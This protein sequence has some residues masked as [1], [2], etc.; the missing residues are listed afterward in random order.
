ME[1]GRMITDRSGGGRSIALLRAAVLVLVLTGGLF[2]FSALER[3]I[4]RGDEA[5]TGVRISGVLHEEIGRELFD[6]RVHSRAEVLE[7]QYP[8]PGTTWWDTA[9][10]LAVHDPKQSPIYYLAAR[11]WVQILGRSLFV[12]RSLSALLGLLCLPLAFLVARELF[13]DRAAAWVAVGVIAVAPVR[14]VYD[15][16]AR[17]YPL[18]AVLIL[19]STWLLLVAL[20]RARTDGGTGR[21]LFPLYAAALTAA[22]YTHPLTVLVAAAHVAFVVIDERRCWT[23]PARAHMAAVA[24]AGLCYAPLAA[25]VAAQ[26]SAPH[27]GLAWLREAMPPLDWISC[28]AVAVVRIFYD[29]AAPGS[30]PAWMMLGLVPLGIAAAAGSLVLWAAPASAR[31]LLV[32]QIAVT[33]V[34]FV[35]AD[36][37]LGGFRTCVLRYLFP[38]VIALQLCVAFGIAHLL[39]DSR[40]IWRAAG[41]ASAIVLALSGVVSG[42]AIVTAEVWWLNPVGNRI[43]RIARVVHAADRP[44][45]I[46]PYTAP[47]QGNHVLA[48]IRSLE[49]GVA[50]LLVSDPPWPDVPSGYGSVF[51]YQVPDQ[52]LVELRQGGWSTVEEDAKRLYRLHRRT[53]E[54]DE[55]PHASLPPR[56]PASQPRP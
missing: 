27:H 37:L 43:Q 7:Y 13:P 53:E 20:R 14:V 19:L 54:E 5:S 2:R 32:L 22:L 56:G 31:R 9:R 1:P 34:P 33:W 24:V 28:A 11:A 49:D 42:R 44:L 50:L 39:A 8:R 17:P 38:G 47:G 41:L 3:T 10:N 15:R 12:L 35:A 51:A 21:T 18:W 30:E 6:G 48:V 25:R 40:R 29:V 52:L 26:M 4:I 23:R 36:L 55:H 16:D 46:T 45:L